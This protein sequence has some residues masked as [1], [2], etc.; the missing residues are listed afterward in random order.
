MYKYA[1]LIVLLPGLIHASIS[2]SEPAHSLRIGLAEIFSCTDGD[3]L[4]LYTYDSELGNGDFYEDVGCSVVYTNNVPGTYIFAECNNFFTTCEDDVTYSDASA[5]VGFVS[6]YTFE[7]YDPEAGGEVPPPS[8]VVP[9]GMQAET[10]ASVMF[11]SG[12][13]MM[14]YFFVFTVRKWKSSPKRL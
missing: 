3:I 14:L 8:E 6:A 13:A 11:V 5:D 4:R 10:F 12:S 9:Q 1:L 7:W 2:P